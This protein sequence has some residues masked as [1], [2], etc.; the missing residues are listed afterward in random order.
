[1]SKSISRAQLVAEA[2][3]GQ[4]RNREGRVKRLDQARYIALLVQFYKEAEDSNFYCMADK[5][6]EKN[7]YFFTDPQR[8]IAECML[9]S[10]FKKERREIYIS[11]TRQ[12][13]KTQIVSMV[14]EFCYRH[15]SEIFGEP[16][17]VAIIAPEKGTA[18]EVFARIK[19]YIIANEVDLVIDTRYE[20]Q[21]I[22]GDTIRLYGIYEGA[23]GGT[24][25][26]RTFSMVI[27]D[28]AHLGDDSKFIDQVIPATNRTSGP[29]VLI[30]NG[31]FRDCY[32]YRGLKRGTN[33][34]KGQY[35]FRYTYKTLRKYMLDLGERGLES[36]KLWVDNT[37]RYITNVGG[38]KSLFVRKNIFC[39][40][41]LQL[42]GF[43]SEENLKACPP[44]A[45]EDVAEEFFIG[46]DVAHS[47]MDRGVA[48]IMD[49]N[50]NMLDLWITK[51]IGEVIPLAIQAKKLY[52]RCIES[53]LMTVDGENSLLKCIGV[54]A[55]GLGIGMAE[56]LE[57]LFP[58]PIKRFVFTAKAKQDWFINFRDSVI[59][60]VSAERV[61]FN[62]HPE[63]LEPTARYAN[64][65]TTWADAELWGIALKEIFDLE[66]I[67]MRNGLFG[68]HAPTSKGGVLGKSVND[69]LVDAMV[70]VNS[71]VGYWDGF[72]PFTR[73]RASLSPAVKDGRSLSFDLGIPEY[74][75]DSSGTVPPKL[76]AF[77]LKA[78][79]GGDPF[80]RH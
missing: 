66:V 16:F 12:F 54:D 79:R 35:V 25:E 13:G 5:A 42:G 22:N 69:D 53:G 64:V 48:A 7:G 15:Y 49:R 18:A 21:T 3:Q 55:T 76:K 46:F 28:E 59:T 73:R 57:Q 10:V 50:K 17:A 34:E 43:L 67:E 30:G 29:I 63:T 51:E 71:V 47:G 20:T 56:V 60:D 77:R 70:I 62:R 40:W 44:V 52:D 58:V 9:A 72:H 32:Y 80:L 38:E 65:M 6:K 24:I 4:L 78:T 37:D 68:F 8:E 26:G 11:L 31:G 39:E 74:L 61:R 23:L 19:N 75:G 36:C 41:A 2:R 33:E 14:T 1:M 45:Q 27:R